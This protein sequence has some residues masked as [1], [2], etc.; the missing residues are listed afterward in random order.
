[1]TGIVGI[2]VQRP[3]RNEVVQAAGRDPM[4]HKEVC[5][6]GVIGIKV[7]QGSLPESHFIV[8]VGEW[9]DTVEE[10]ENAT[11]EPASVLILGR[12][13][14]M[15]LNDLLVRETEGDCVGGRID[16]VSVLRIC[17]AR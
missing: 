7:G 6:V 11:P 16:D 10:L 14:V 15:R 2:A 17:P 4:L 9:A 12:V 3:S 8:F 13:R 1:M 5:E